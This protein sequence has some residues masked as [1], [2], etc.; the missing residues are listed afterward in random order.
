VLANQ[1]DNDEEMIEHH[2]IHEIYCLAWDG[3]GEVLYCGE[4]DGGINLWNLK[5]DTETQ[6]GKKPDSTHNEAKFEKSLYHT[7]TIMDMI[8]MPKLQFM[9]SGALDCNLILWDTI[10]YEVKRIYKEHTRGIVSLAFNE[11]LILLFSAG[12]DHDLCVWN[13]YIDNLI[14]KI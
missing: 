14:F 5:T 7:G 10:T 13:P 8:A 3:I 11:S 1:P 6:L 12:F 2:F 9:A 4:K